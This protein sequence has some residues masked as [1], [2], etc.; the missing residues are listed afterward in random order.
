[1]TQ[2][3]ET[4]RP[5]AIVLQCGADSLAGDRL[6]C[7]NLSLRGTVV[8]TCMENLYS[9]DMNVQARSTVA[10]LLCLCRILFMY[11]FK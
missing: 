9:T 3:I 7:F 6:G 4:Y 10:L 8:C 1:M 5:N 11:V 2:V